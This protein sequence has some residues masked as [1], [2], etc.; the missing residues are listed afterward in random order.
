MS[1]K[2][3]TLWVHILG[4]CGYCVMTHICCGFF[5]LAHRCDARWEFFFQ[6]QSNKI[7]L[8]KCLHVF[9]NSVYY[10]TFFFSVP[11]KKFVHDQTP[12]PSTCALLGLPAQF[13]WGITKWKVS[14]L[15][16]FFF[17]SVHIAL[18]QVSESWGDLPSRP[19]NHCSVMS[20]FC[21]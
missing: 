1:K 9:H 5:V 19:L 18:L 17:P 21:P 12:K 3:C 13:D 6:M 8:F 16:Y 7:A 11:Q 4:G 2:F 10:F 14:A 20:S 15:N